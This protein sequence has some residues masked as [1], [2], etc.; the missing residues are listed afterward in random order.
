MAV[1]MRGSGI[2]PWAG[3]IAAGTGWGLHQQVVSDALHFDCS[4]TADG[5]GIALGIVALA[6]V[7]AGAIVSW[8]A[9]PAADAPVPAATM[10]RFIVHMSLMAAALAALGIVFL[11]LAGAMLPGCRP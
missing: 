7:L 9:L 3:M 11:L 5:T 4:A 8:L 10:R 6:I 1:N 2:A